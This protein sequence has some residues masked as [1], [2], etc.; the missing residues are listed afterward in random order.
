MKRK[1]L[2]GFLVS[3]SFTLLLVSG[4][5]SKDKPITVTFEGLMSEHKWAIKDLND[6]LPSDWSPYEYLTF[7]MKASNAQEFDL[8]LYDAHGVRTLRINPFQGTWIRASIPLA[9]FQKRNTR[10]SD[11]AA[12]GKTAR[13]GYWIHFTSVVGPI[14]QVDSLGVSMRMPVGQQTME[15]RNIRLTMAVED[16][17]LGPVPVV[18]EFGQWILADW[19]GKAKTLDDLKK[20]WIAEEESLSYDEFRI[21]KYGGFL[22]G[23]TKATGF[24]RVE[25]INGIWWFVD[26]D[27]YLFFSAGSTCIRP[28]CDMA[29]VPG[30][31]YIY[32]ALPPEDVIAALNPQRT[33]TPSS[34]TVRRPSPSLYAW[35]LYRRFG[36]D[37]QEKWIDLT[38][39]RMKSWGL[40]T[41]ANWSDASLG[42]SQRIPYVAGI[43]GWGISA[44][45]MG[46]PD[47]YAPDYAAIVDAAAE[48]QC[49]PLKDDPYLIGYFIGNEQPWPRREQELIE[50]ILEGEDTPMKV[51][52]KKYLAEG[53]SPERRKSFVY[54]TFSIFLKTVNAAIK[55]YDPNHLNMGIRYGGSVPDEIIDVSKNHF[56][57]FSM[58]VYGYSVP[59]STMQKVSEITGLPIV[60]GEYHF[61]TPARGLSPWLAQVRNL[62]ER[63]VGYRYYVE[64]AAAH[65]ALIGTHWFQWID[66]P[67]TGRNDG[68]NG[69]I[70]FVDVTDRPYTDLVEASKATFKRLFDVH[71]GKE[72]PFSRQA[73]RQ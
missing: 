3:L 69:L 66:Q 10:G 8:N 30:R 5:S 31:E 35:N 36:N 22:D 17:V 7:D 46:L 61:G 24:F 18:D 63:G 1:F 45:T 33:T 15:I 16:S 73:L 29:R 48:R 28:R 56:D 25:K 52:L 72:P 6:K 21:S 27:G 12:V 55:K 41:V 59:V 44:N 13:D 2:S 51:A 62:E 37:W 70:G 64:N 67:A 20:D 4:C 53:D 68:E 57:V 34:R 9:N 14:T 39:K 40:N 49:T 38:V 50:V 58:N 11:M 32:A 23:R 43:S 60:I 42:R 54:E 19:P 26:P 65:P 47:V 71:A